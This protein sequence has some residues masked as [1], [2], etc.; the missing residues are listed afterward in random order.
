M[1]NY[2]HLLL[3]ILPS[4]P[5]EQWNHS[6]TLESLVILP[7]YISYMMFWYKFEVAFKFS[8]TFILNESVVF[9]MQSN[10]AH[11]VFQAKEEDF[12]HIL[13]TCGKKDIN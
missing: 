9:H 1:C 10:G 11:R 5:Q 12:N 13:D 6:W 7:N 8:Y 3:C 2:I 4:M